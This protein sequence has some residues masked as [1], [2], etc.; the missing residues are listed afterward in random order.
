MR[1]EIIEKITFNLY[2]KYNDLVFKMHERYQMLSEL[3]S[4]KS[5]GFINNDEYLEKYSK[6]EKEIYMYSVKLNRYEYFYN[7][8]RERLLKGD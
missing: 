6:I 8:Y 7:K 2:N 5:S 4:Y 3:R 1:K